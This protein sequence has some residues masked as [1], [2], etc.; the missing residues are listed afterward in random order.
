MLSFSKKGFRFHKTLTTVIIAVYLFLG[1]SADLFHNEDCML[2]AVQPATTD[3][4]THNDPCPA[5]KFLAGHNS[6]EVG[7]DSILGG[8]EFI[9]I[10]QFIP[11]LTIL[12]H[13]EWSSSITSRAPPLFSIS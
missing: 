4:L 7:Q 2:G 12:N 9:D 8:N 3:V 5:C 10:S 6:I 11:F 1:T 13:D